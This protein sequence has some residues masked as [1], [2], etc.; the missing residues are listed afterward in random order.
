MLFRSQVAEHYQRLAV[1]LSR[2][3]EEYFAKRDALIA[4]YKAA[5]RRS[6]IQE[7]LKALKWEARETAIPEDLC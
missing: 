2:G 3:K 5:G 7:A 1:D 6:E 4:E